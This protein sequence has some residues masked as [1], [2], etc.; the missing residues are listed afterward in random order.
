MTVRRRPPNA[1]SS[2]LRPLKWFNL[3]PQPSTTSSCHHM[4]LP[5]SAVHHL[6]PLQSRSGAHVG[7]SLPLRDATPRLSVLQPHLGTRRWRQRIPC[8]ADVGA[9]YRAASLGVSLWPCKIF[10]LNI[11]PRSFSRLASPLPSRGPVTRVT[12]R[13]G[14]RPHS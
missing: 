10:I 1:R 12:R 5:I 4:P 14:S 3:A 8:A 13:H 9:C 2:G 6:P 7:A 11:R